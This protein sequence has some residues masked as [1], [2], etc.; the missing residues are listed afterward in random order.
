MSYDWANRIRP[1]AIVVF[2]RDDGSI[3]AVP[4]HDNVKD[5]RFYR[6]PGGEIEFGETAEAAARREVREEL[7]TDVADL[8]L[9]TVNENIFTF[10]GQQGHEL[11]WVFEG[12]FSDPS[13]YDRD[14]IECDEGGFKFEAHWV[15]LAIFASSETPLYPDGLLV[16]LSRG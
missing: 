14:V 10:L 5:Q 16:M 11:V 13:F 3:L 8:R 4:G 12:R 15:P 2:R 6:P 1:I 7:D 9:L